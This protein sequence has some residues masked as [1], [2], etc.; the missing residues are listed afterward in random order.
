MCP[1]LEKILNSSETQSTS[2]QSLSFWASYETAG[3]AKVR[4]LVRSSSH[5]SSHLHKCFLRRRSHATLAAYSPGLNLDRVFH[6]LTQENKPNRKG[7]RSW[8]VRFSDWFSSQVLALQSALFI[9]ISRD[10]IELH[11]DQKVSFCFPCL[12]LCKHKQRG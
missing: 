10:R 3:A 8:P 11:L 5:A 7:L 9:Q 2:M 6:S 1:R 12:Y 4:V